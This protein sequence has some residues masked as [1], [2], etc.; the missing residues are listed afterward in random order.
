MKPFQYATATSAE[1]AADLVA[2]NG[3]YFA[4]GIDVLGQIK[5]G[6]SAPDI[7]VNVKEIPG[8]HDITPGPATWTVG[9]NVKL[10]ALSEDEGILNTFPGLAEAAAD[11]GSP[12]IRN[13]ASVGGNLSQH[14]RCW[15]YR[16][17]DI[18]CLKGGGSTCF[19]RV[20]RNR[21]H[22]LFSSNPCISPV[23]S[24]L[25]PMLAALDAQIVVFRDGSE[26]SMSVSEFY[27][28]AWYNPLSHNSLR[29]GDLV[30]RVEIPT[31]TAAS[32]YMQASEKGAFDWALV[33]CAAAAN[34]DGNTLSNVRVA[35]GAIAPGPHMSDDANGLLEGQQFTAA[36]AEEAA[37]VLLDGAAPQT[38]NGY[39]V[40]M[41]KALVKRT[42]TR[43]VS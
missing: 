11:V 10:T 30:V 25:A 34:V 18:E 35:L 12:Q 20:G 13:L 28:M 4:G 27:E 6:I 7:L 15:Y 40:P 17:N 29:P 37:D 16:H 33:S 3:Q 26:V 5:E 14:S 21:H 36:L 2:D 43:L 24:N 23:V 32:T 22:C 42:L 41:A 19:A 1:S 9:A 8:T 31:A 39:K 38:D